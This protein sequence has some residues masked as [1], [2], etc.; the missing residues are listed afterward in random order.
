LKR[1]KCF[2]VRSDTMWSR[3]A[4][5]VARHHPQGTDGTIG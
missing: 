2:E 4:D 3:D 1:Q 5:A